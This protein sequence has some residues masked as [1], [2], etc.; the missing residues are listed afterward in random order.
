MRINKRPPNNMFLKVVF[1]NLCLMVKQ[2]VINNALR[3][4]SVSE[5]E[6]EERTKLCA[7]PL[8]TPD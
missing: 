5:R 8:I 7:L 2:E 1:M 4:G 3:Q 6:Q